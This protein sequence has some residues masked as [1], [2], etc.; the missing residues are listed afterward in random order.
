MYILSK[1]FDSAAGYITFA[2]F[3]YLRLR[4][5]VYFFLDPTMV[6]APLAY[7]ALLGAA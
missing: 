7:L 1:A 6:W 5:Y 4:I 3:L 2:W